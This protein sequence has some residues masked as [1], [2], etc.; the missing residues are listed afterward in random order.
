M[1]IMGNTMGSH[2]TRAQKPLVTSQ[3]KTTSLDAIKKTSQMIAR[4]WALN[5]Q[6]SQMLHLIKTRI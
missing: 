5:R 2:K 4:M 1:N 6:G 3:N